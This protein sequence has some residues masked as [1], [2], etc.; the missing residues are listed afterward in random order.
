MLLSPQLVSDETRPTQPWGATS[1][2][3]E[4]SLMANTNGGTETVD[5][6]MLCKTTK[7]QGLFHVIAHHHKVGSRP[8]SKT[9]LLWCLQLQH[10]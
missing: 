6:V 3:L 4:G 1:R 8:L 10:Q 5:G 2:W 7:K 9:T